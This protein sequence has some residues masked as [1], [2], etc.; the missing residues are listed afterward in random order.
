MTF[1]IEKQKNPPRYPPNIRNSHAQTR[2]TEFLSITFQIRPIF[3]L[4]M[5]RGK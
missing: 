1:L 5:Y 2:K 3:G 4:N